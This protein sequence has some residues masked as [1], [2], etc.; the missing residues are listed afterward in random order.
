[1]TTSMIAAGKLIK[2]QKSIKVTEVPKLLQA[3][4]D[5]MMSRGGASLAR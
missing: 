3:A 1:M 5:A 4:L 2:G